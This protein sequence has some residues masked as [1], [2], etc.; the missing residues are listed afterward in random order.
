MAANQP[1]GDPGMSDDAVA[2]ATGRDWAAWKAH[3]DAAGAAEMDHAAIA[4]SLKD[5]GVRP[6]WRQMVTVGYERMIGRRELGQ[7]CAGTYAA[8]ASKT[9]AGDKDAALAA[10]QELVSERMQFAGAT[11]AAEPRITRSEK[12]RYW[13]V[14]LDN[15]TRVTIGFSDKAGGRAGSRA[16]IGVQHEKLADADAVGAAKAFW[17]D[18]LAQL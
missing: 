8:S 17:K 1:G 10:W 3:L 11:A 2:Q 9:F 18:L 5:L 16:S 13:R 6:W 14:D 15:G 12:W 4:R 7:T